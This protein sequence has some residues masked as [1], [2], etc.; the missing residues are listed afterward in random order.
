M[1]RSDF[2]RVGYAG[3]CPGCIHFQ[4]GLSASRSHNEICRSRIGGRLED[5]V[6]GRARKDRVLQRRKDQLTRKLERQYE[7]A[8]KNDVAVAAAA[9]VAP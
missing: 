8:S 5:T 3:G 1:E 4:A 2:V 7:L 6:E 9:R